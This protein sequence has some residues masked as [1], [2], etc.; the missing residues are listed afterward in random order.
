MRYIVAVE[1]DLALAAGRKTDDG[2]DQGCL[3]HSVPAENG[4]DV[5]LFDLKGDSLEDIAIPVVGVDIAYSK[6]DYSIPR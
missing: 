6:H 4:D 3:P 1:Q 5:S 2:T